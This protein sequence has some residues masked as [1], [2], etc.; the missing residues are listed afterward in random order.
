MAAHTSFKILSLLTVLT[1]LSLAS[2]ITAISTEDVDAVLLLLRAQGHVLFANAIST[3]DLLF[4]ILSLPSLTLLAPSD[5]TLFALDMTNTPHFYISTLRLHALPLRLS[6]YQLRILS[7]GSFLQTLLP[8]RQ[9]RVLRSQ[10]LNTFVVDGGG[11]DGSAVQVVFPGLYYS[12][13]VAVHGLGGILTFRSKI[14]GS[15]LSPP[16]VPKFNSTS[17]GNNRNRTVYYPPVPR[18]NSSSSSNNRSNTVFFRP[19]PRI[20][21]I[22]PINQTIR[23]PPVNRTMVFPVSKSPTTPSNHTNRTEFSPVNRTAVVSPSPGPAVVENHSPSPVESPE[24]GN[25]LRGSSS[26]LALSSENSPSP[27]PMRPDGSKP[28]KM[29]EVLASGEICAVG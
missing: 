12:R 9:L 19:V 17:S 14:G 29:G 2:T 13:D 28:R 1:L 8:S 26:G 20:P 15:V 25:V 18:T 22:L 4:D 23:P 3:S 6:W 11:G 27:A 7:N 10:E 16:P 5:P 24:S 21:E